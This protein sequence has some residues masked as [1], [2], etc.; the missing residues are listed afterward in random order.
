[1]ISAADMKVATTIFVG[2]ISDKATDTLVRQILLVS[3]MKGL[4]DVILYTWFSIVL[5]IVSVKSTFLCN[6]CSDA[7]ELKAGNESRM[8]LGS[9]KVWLFI[10]VTILGPRV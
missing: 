5:Y 8:P 2:N 7:A 9:F 10:F 1:M 3:S 6:S 4:F